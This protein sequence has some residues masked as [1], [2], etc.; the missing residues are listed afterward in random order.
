MKGYIE[1]CT[2]CE[3]LGM[4]VANT[5]IQHKDAHKCTWFKYRKTVDKVLVR[6]K[7]IGCVHNV[8]SMKGLGEGLSNHMIGIC[9]LG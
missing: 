8:R 9:M 1:Y 5:Y 2:V 7:L 3:S 4:N 6:M